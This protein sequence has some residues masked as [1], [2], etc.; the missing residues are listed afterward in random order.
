MTN[1]EL[2]DNIITI[3]EERIPYYEESEFHNLPY[4]EKLLFHREVEQAITD[5]MFSLLLLEDNLHG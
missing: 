4:D 2:I 5:M 1:F 3:A